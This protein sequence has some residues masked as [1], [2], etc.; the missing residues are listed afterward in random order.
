MVIFNLKITFVYTISPCPDHN[1]RNNAEKELLLV[2]LERIITYLKDKRSECKR[3]TGSCL[4]QKLA[5]VLL[6]T[7]CCFPEVFTNTPFHFC[8]VL[9]KQ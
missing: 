3:T 7:P 6:I 5:Y 8:L 4:F 9:Q 2:D 1:P